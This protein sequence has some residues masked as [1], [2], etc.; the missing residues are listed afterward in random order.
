MMKVNEKLVRRQPSAFSKYYSF[1]VAIDES[2]ELLQNRRAIQ[3][4]IFLEMTPLG[5]KKTC[6]ELE[7]DIFEEKKRFPDPGKA[8]VLKRKVAKMRFFDFSLQY[9]GLPWIRKAFFLL[10]NVKFRFPACFYP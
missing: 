6:V 3:W 10:E 9:T 4:K 2:Q 5:V 8:C 1:F 7:F